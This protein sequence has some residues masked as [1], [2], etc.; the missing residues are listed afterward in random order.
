M[1]NMPKS[2]GEL[3]FCG[4][5]FALGLLIMATSVQI[6]FGKF[7]EPGPGLFPLLCGLILCVQSMTLCLVKQ[8]G[9]ERENVLSNREAAAKFIWMMISF[10][11]WILLMPVLG[12]LS[13]TFLV[14]LAVSKIMRMRGWVKPLLL[15]GANTAFSY[16]L[17]GF[18]LAIDLP[19]GFWS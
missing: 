14:T 15:A 2:K 9:Q 16:L 17:F 18:L 13:L 8:K 12:W 5:L 10:I 6:G 7:T 4:L 1:K 19:N 11:S 3:V